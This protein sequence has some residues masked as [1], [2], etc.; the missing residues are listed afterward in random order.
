MPGRTAEVAASMMGKVNVRQLRTE[1]RAGRLTGEEA[2]AAV[3]ALGVDQM[4]RMARGVVKSKATE[5]N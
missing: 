5:I 4:G 1:L 3:A 2:A